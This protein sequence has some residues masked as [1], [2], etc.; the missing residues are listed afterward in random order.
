MNC[1]PP[2]KPRARIGCDN[3]SL[4]MNQY[5]SALRVVIGGQSV[6]FDD[7]LGTG[8]TINHDASGTCDRVTV[9]V[10]L[11]GHHAACAVLRHQHTGVGEAIRAQ[12]NIGG[13]LWPAA[14]RDP[15][16]GCSEIEGA[17]AVRRIAQCL[18]GIAV[19]R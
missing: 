12:R 19:V 2:C 8:Q 13:A 10:H 16:L 6:P 1:Q 5:L 15:V 7:A 14:Y 17:L 9:G 11:I 18:P 4:G 3:H